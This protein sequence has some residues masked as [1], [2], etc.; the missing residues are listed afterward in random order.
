MTCLETIQAPFQSPP[1]RKAPGPLMCSGGATFC[2][3]FCE[4]YGVPG[5]VRLFSSPLGMVPDLPAGV[6]ER[7]LF[8]TPRSDQRPVE[9]QVHGGLIYKQ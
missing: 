2:R 6:S 7:W 5:A 1:R 9:G 3:C 4:Y 8:P